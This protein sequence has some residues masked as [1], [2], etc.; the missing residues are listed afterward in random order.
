MSG[1]III[2]N[3][4][5]SVIVPTKNSERVIEKCL[6]SIK[7]QTYRDIEIIVVDNYSSDNTRKIAEKYGTILLRGPERSSQRNFG[8][9]QSH[10]EYLL[11]IDSDMEL[12]PT[13]VE[14]CVEANITRRAT[15]V[16]IPEVSVG[17]GFWAACKALERSCYMGDDSIEAARFFTKDAFFSIGCFDPKI[18]GEEDWDLHLR[19]RKA[20]FN[21]GRI[22]SFIKHDEGR[23]SLRKT[24]LK[25][26]NYG[27]SIMLYTKKHPKEAIAQ[28]TI[29]R[30][31]FIKCWK[32]LARDPVHTLGMIFM[33]V[34]E[35]SAAWLGTL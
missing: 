11:F 27:N 19:I 12:T 14:E 6:Q 20:G 10:G 32:K 22:K 23:L 28:F 35:F 18:N 1:G 24:M 4:T 8:A 7:R 13:V 21:F 5:V 25:K 2:N 29:V 26:R 34:C 33:K 9:K 17:D 15:A 16:I 30:P 31:A 3:Y